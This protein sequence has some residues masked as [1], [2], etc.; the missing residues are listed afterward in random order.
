M[1]IACPLSDL[2]LSG[3]RSDRPLSAA[4]SKEGTASGEVNAQGFAQGEN[5]SP[6]LVAVRARNPF[7]A[8]VWSKLLAP[9]AVKSHC[10]CP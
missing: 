10:V 5:P 1:P 6:E 2:P 9:K 8:L 4:S 7:P 3:A